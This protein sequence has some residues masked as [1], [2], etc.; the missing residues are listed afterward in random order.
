MGESNTES[1]TGV[2]LAGGRT[3]VWVEQGA[4]HWR[5]GRTTVVVPGTRIRQVEAVEKS[6]AVLLFEDAQVDTA[7]TVRHRNRDMVAALGAEIEAIMSDADPSGNRQPLQRHSVQAWPVRTLADLRD[8][9]LH[10]SPWWRRAL[11]YVVLGLPLAVLLPVGPF[12]GF[13]AWLLLP[14][15][16]A[17]LRMWVGMAELDTRWVMWRRGITVR[18]RYEADPYSEAT[19]NCVVH[20]RTL[21]GRHVTARPALR[22]RRDEIRYDPQDP[23]RVLAPTC[24]AWLGLALAAFMLTGFWGVVFSIPAILWLIDLLALPF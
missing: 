9:V 19:N 11:W 20:F 15:G 22:G 24:V 14:V 23:S 13:F 6:L 10:G 5:R 4:L 1:A 21:D 2:V 8:R 3:R 7:M 12:L 18:A 16:V 17:L